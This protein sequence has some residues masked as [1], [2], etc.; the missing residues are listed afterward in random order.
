MDQHH[1]LDKYIVEQAAHYGMTPEKHAC[2]MGGAATYQ[3][4]IDMGVVREP[5]KRN[6][7]VDGHEFDDT[8]SAWLGDGKFPPF[9][10]FDIDAQE[11]LPGRY[12][13]RVEA[14]CAMVCI[15]SGKPAL[16]IRDLHLHDPSSYPAPAWDIAAFLPNGSWYYSGWDFYTTQ[17][18]AEIALAG[19]ELKNLNTEEALLA[20]GFEVGV[21]K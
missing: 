7:C 16:L 17:D 10:V 21:G 3:E 1:W 5:A 13:S 20:E 2:L 4:K 9:A 18:T 19:L 11:N 12:P 6:L 8:E 14:E 15:Q